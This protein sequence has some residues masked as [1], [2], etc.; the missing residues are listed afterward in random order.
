[1][2]KPRE[3]TREEN[4]GFVSFFRFLGR[5]QRTPGEICLHLSLVCLAGTEEAETIEGGS[6]GEVESARKEG[7]IQRKTLLPGRK[8]E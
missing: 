6:A 1:M 8:W 7:G 3:G 5:D 2:G 4:K